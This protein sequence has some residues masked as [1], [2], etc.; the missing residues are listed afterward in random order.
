LNL[1]QPCNS[2]PNSNS[3]CRTQ[4]I[5]TTGN[6][7]FTTLARP[8]TNNGTL[9][10][11]LAAEGTTVCGVLG[12]FNLTKELTE[13]G[14]VTCSVFAGDSDLSCAVLSHGFR[15]LFCV[16]E[17]MLYEENEMESK[18]K[19]S[20]MFENRE[21]YKDRGGESVAVSGRAKPSVTYAFP[22]ENNHPLEGKHGHT[23]M[24]IVPRPGLQL[25]Q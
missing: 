16:I 15:D 10:G 5:S 13:C 20:E 23:N 2:T 19:V 21:I 7:L 11:V 4:T 18:Y 12:H 14:T 25:Q 6:N 8:D 17:K 24:T 9:H 1:P 3:T 22:S